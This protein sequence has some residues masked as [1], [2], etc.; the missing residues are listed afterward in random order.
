MYGYPIKLPIDLIID[1]GKSDVP[2]DTYV[3]TLKTAMR[4][5][6]PPVTRKPPQQKGYIDPKMEFT[7]HVFVKINNRQGL[8]PNFRGPYKVVERHDKYFVINI[9]GKDDKVSIDRLKPAVLTAE[10]DDSGKNDN[11]SSNLEFS[12]HPVQFRPPENVQPKPPE[13]VQPKPPE[14]V[15]HEDNVS[16]GETSDNN[17]PKK[18]VTFNVPVHT[19]YGRKVT[20]T[21]RYEAK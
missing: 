11:D 14:N 15:Q 18:S 1:T 9:N 7:S 13:N 2:T 10:L 20:P 5:L 12:D 6:R 3:D 8:Q 21:R 4:T 19:R 16:V 17:L